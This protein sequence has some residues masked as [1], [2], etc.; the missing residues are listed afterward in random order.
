MKINKRRDCKT[1]CAKWQKENTDNVLLLGKGM[2]SWRRKTCA[3]H[4]LAESRINYQP[5]PKIFASDFRHTRLLSSYLLCFFHQTW[6]PALRF[7]KNF[8]ID[9]PMGR[10]DIKHVT[11][12][13]VFLIEILRAMVLGL[14]LTFGTTSLPLQLQL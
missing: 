13:L 12:T 6:F 4:I 7:P 5:V 3:T 2:I 8:I 9:P 10:M 14:Q 11:E 1:A